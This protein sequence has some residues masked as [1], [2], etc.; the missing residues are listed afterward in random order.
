MSL[1]SKQNDILALFNLESED[2]ED[3]SYANEADLAIIRILLRP[4]YPPCPDCGNKNVL[5]KGYDVDSG[6]TATGIWIICNTIP[7]FLQ[8]APG[9]SLRNDL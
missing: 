1:S 4:D 8:M 3:I 2:I 6:K 9:L 7:A 5:V